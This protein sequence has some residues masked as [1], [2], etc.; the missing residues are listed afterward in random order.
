MLLLVAAALRG[1]HMATGRCHGASAIAEISKFDQLMA[2][3]QVVDDRWRDEARPVKWAPHS[4][5]C[6]YGAAELTAQLVDPAITAGTDPRE[7]HLVKGVAAIQT[8]LGTRRCADRLIPC[9][10]RAP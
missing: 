10:P 4:A 9:S 8:N 6:G 7:L 1:S 3:E 2:G 5:P